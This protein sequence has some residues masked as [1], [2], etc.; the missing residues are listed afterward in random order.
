MLRSCI[1]VLGAIVACSTANAGEGRDV[2]PVSSAPMGLYSVKRGVQG[3]A[4]L[5]SVRLLLHI[6]ASKDAFGEPVALAPD[7]FYAVSDTLSLGIIHDGP[8]GLLT[9]ASSH[10][11]LCFTGK[12]GGC[13]KVYDNIGFDALYGLAFGEFNFSLHSSFFILSFSDPTPLMLTLGAAMKFHFSEEIALFLDPQ[14]GIGLNHRD[15]NKDQFFL[16][17]QLQFQVAHST[18]LDL[19]TGVTGQLSN[20]GDTYRIP[21]GLAVVFNLSPHVD[22]GLKFAFD[23]LLGQVPTG[24]SRADARSLALIMNIR[25]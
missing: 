9:T 12:T 8:M 21:L 24:T 13:P 14:F 2:A 1:I 6:N 16:P 4:G 10:P 22:L 15:V 23:N 11:G 25:S 18:A 19:L 20:F 17:V 5:L 3:P 7:L